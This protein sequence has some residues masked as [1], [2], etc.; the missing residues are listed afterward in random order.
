MFEKK[1][2]S[3]SSVVERF[4]GGLEIARRAWDRLAEGRRACPG[5]LERTQRVTDVGLRHFLSTHHLMPVDRLGDN[6]FDS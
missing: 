6:W 3:I 1:K 5:S 2:M 4:R